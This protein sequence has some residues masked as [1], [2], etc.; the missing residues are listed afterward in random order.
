MLAITGIA[1]VAATRWVVTPWQVRGA[2]MEPTLR[3]GDRVIV[4]LL[5]FSRR[6]PRAREIVVLSGPGGEEMVKRIAAEPYNAPM[7]APAL[8]A[9]SPLESTYVVLGDNPTAS[10]DSR[11]FGRVPRH[12]IHGRVVWRYWPLSAWGA[13]DTRSRS[14]D[15]P[16]P[17]SP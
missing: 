6:T 16:A 15:L 14:E 5:T 3:D 11:A 4:D 1:V 17:A 2:S 10:S 7:P 13:I 8:A 9:E 12:R